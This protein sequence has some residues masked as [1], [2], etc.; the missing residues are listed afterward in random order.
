MYIYTEKGEM[1]I[2]IASYL[3]IFYEAET[4]SF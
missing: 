4:A 2:F 1:I 3:V